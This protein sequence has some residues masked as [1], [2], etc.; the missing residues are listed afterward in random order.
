[1]RGNSLASYKHLCT[2][3]PSSTRHSPQWPPRRS[4]SSIS[5]RSL[6]AHTVLLISSA[7][8]FHTSL[9]IGNLT[10]VCACSSSSMGPFRIC[11]SP[12]NLALWSATSL[13]A[14]VR[15]INILASSGHC[16]G[17]ILTALILANLARSPNLKKLA[18]E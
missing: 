12:D 9:A 8:L 11:F 4:T 6:S 2:L 5:M 17:G 18:I 7:I 3:R 13:L 15:P 16:D 10:H 14:E 1:M